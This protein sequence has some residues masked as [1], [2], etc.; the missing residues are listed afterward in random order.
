MDFHCGAQVLPGVG[1]MGLVAP[2]HMG[3][4]FP[5]QEWT[6][7]PCT[8]RQV[9]SHWTTR[10]VPHHQFLNSA[11]APRM[12]FS[13]STSLTLF[14]SFP[15]LFPFGNL[16]TLSSLLNTPRYKAQFLA[17]LFHP[18]SS[19]L[20][21]WG[22]RPVPPAEKISGAQGRDICHLWGPGHGSHGP[23][24][25]LIPHVKW[26][27]GH[28]MTIKDRIAVTKKAVNNKFWWGWGEMCYCI[29]PESVR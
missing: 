21:P 8:G 15:S 16:L 14:S 2:H 6:R 1:C 3:P 4:C 29:A 19:S 7:V 12:E 26:D 9:L 24:A 27:H 17:C 5:N 23:W 25:S 18:M 13:K 11:R 10:E 28:Q 22:E 20:S